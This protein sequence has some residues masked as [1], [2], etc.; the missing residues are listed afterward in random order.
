MEKFDDIS[1]DPLLQTFA[2]QRE[3]A[4]L[5][6]VERARIL[7][8][9]RAGMNFW[10]QQDFSRL[11]QQVFD[12]AM[13][14]L[15]TLLGLIEKELPE[16]GIELDL[17]FWA[18]DG[19]KSIVCNCRHIKFNDDSGGILVSALPKP[20]EKPSPFDLAI[21]NSPFAV[22]T[23]IDRQ[24]STTYE[25]N[26]SSPEDQETLKEIARLLANPD[27]IDDDEEPQHEDQLNGHTN[28]LAKS[29]KAEEPIHTNGHD[30]ANGLNGHSNL[31]GHNQNTD[32]TSPKK[33]VED[34]PK[35]N[36]AFF[37][38]VSH[39]M[40]TPLNSIIGF[41]E[42]MKDGHLGD[43]GNQKYKGY[44]DDIYDSAQHALCLVNDLLDLS[45]V[46]SGEFPLEKVAVDLNKSIE[47][48]ISSLQ[49]QTA[50]A[51]LVI[52][53]SLNTDLQHISVDAR[54]IRQ[55]IL[56]LLSNAIKFTAPGGQIIVSTQTTTDDGK[57]RLRVRDTGIGMSEEDLSTALQPFGQLDT[58]LNSQHNGTGLGLPLTKALAEAN[59]AE[60]QISSQEGKG[61]LVEV[62]FPYFEGA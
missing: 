10:Q 38:K 21:E 15:N 25:N 48:C 39:E 14:A 28:G 57:A 55:I 45:K 49:P 6:D 20:A 23:R 34:I 8:S 27:E 22:P 59:G 31:N 42:M 19:A 18:P 35:S 61:T 47:H 46:Q 3:P 51:R 17:L 33:L 2:G 7:W 50:K 13:P 62:I 26:I 56:N 9:N 40:R 16:D 24:V 43:I 37:A 4:W 53:P 32:T 36:L 52:R 44:V 30:K 58:I 1:K 41:A 60:F 11:K 5:W 54:S 12:R 29:L